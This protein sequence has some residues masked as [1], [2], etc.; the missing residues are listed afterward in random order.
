M[1]TF[2]CHVSHDVNLGNF[3]SFFLTLGGIHVN[4]TSQKNFSCTSAHSNCQGFLN[5]LLYFHILYCCYFYHIYK[6]QYLFHN[7]VLLSEYW[8][9]VHHTWKGV[10]ALL[11]YYIIIRLVKLIGLTIR[12]NIVYHNNITAWGLTKGSYSDGAGWRSCAAARQFLVFLQS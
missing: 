8:F 7:P 4:F 10:L 12:S 5:H 6:G 9:N 3:L 1:F 11:C 2:L